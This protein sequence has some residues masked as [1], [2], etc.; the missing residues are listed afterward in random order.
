MLR[1]L[2]RVCACSSAQYIMFPRKKTNK[3][4]FVGPRH[5]ACEQASKC[6]CVCAFANCEAA[7]LSVSTP[8]SIKPNMKGIRWVIFLTCVSSVHARLLSASCHFSNRF[9]FFTRQI[10]HR[11]GDAAVS[12]ALPKYFAF[13]SFHSDRTN[14]PFRITFLRCSNMRRCHFSLSRLFLQR[15]NKFT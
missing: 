8:Q 5:C 12:R 2:A 10:R 1:A 11:C 3:Y 15:K 7:C 4:C 14:R 9:E 6:V 13:L